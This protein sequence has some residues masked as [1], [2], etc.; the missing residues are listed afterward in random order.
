MPSAKAAI[1]SSSLLAA[2]RH[3]MRTR[4]S[5]ANTLRIRAM[6][7]ALASSF[8]SAHGRRQAIALACYV[9]GPSARRRRALECGTGLQAQLAED[10]GGRAETV[11]RGLQQISPDK[12]SEKQPIG[13]DE[14]GK[15]EAEQH[16]AAGYGKD[17]AIDVHGGPPDRRAETCARCPAPRALPAGLI[18][19]GSIDYIC[20]NSY[21]RNYENTSQ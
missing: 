19:R 13:T 5:F 11:E 2:R 4:R 7:G 16:H 6:S 1:D 21:I 8:A 10:D 12:G 20:V 18:W 3:R 14:P 9:P 15:R 17:C